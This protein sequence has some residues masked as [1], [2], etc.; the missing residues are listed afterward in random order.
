MAHQPKN[1]HKP[2]T[3]AKLQKA[4]LPNPTPRSL[5]FALQ[6]QYATRF[7]MFLIVATS[8]SAALLTTRLMLVGGVGEMWVR[9]LVALAL[10]YLTFFFGVYIWLHLSPYGRH[11]RYGRGGKRSLDGNLPDGLPNI[12]LG[13]SGASGA[14]DDAFQGGGGSFDGGGAGGSWEAGSGDLSVGSSDFSGSNAL[15]NLGVTDVGDE[16]GCLLVIAGI[17]LAI[18]LAC[19]FG[20]TAYVIYQAP[21]I[22]AEVVFEVLLGSRMARGAQALDSAYWA[23]ALLRR[24]WKPFALMAVIIMAF[25]LFSHWAFPQVHTAGEII[26]MI[27]NH[28]QS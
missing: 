14:T 20:A 25:S 19:V 18:V 2:S 10:A 15:G 27:A 21:A 8:I 16:G 5:M 11:L 17:L 9:Y 13:S 23:S 6:V 4:Q 12:N 24:T 22:L 28:G 1:T 7:H 3:H 26:R